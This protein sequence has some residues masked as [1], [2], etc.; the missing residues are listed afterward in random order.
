MLCGPVPWECSLA[1]AL[2]TLRTYGAPHSTHKNEYIVL[3]VGKEPADQAIVGSIVWAFRRLKMSR[4]REMSDCG[5]ELHSVCTHL[6]FF[7]PYCMCVCLYEFLSMWQWIKMGGF[8]AFACLCMV[9]RLCLAI[10]LFCLCK[11]GGPRGRSAIIGDANNF[12][13]R[14][15]T[16][17]TYTAKTRTNMWWFATDKC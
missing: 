16:P 11:N 12:V 3:A 5:Y 1:R 15:N 14:T 17:P 7:N 2:T 4:S 10:C 6:S 8:F 9:L 13:V